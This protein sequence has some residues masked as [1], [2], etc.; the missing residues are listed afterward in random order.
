MKVCLTTLWG[1]PRKLT[2]RGLRVNDNVEAYITTKIALDLAIYLEK[3]GHLA[4]IQTYGSFKNKCVFVNDIRANVF[5]VLTMDKYGF[6]SISA[7]EK[8]EPSKY[9][10]SHFAYELSVVLPWKYTYNVLYPKQQRYGLLSFANKEFTSSAILGI[11]GIRNLNDILEY[12]N[13]HEVLG[14]AILKSYMDTPVLRTKTYDK[15]D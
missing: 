6:G 9:F 7:L 8:S 14:E 12:K 1:F 2:V 5:I 13:F 3:K 4:F 11:C 10:A 15:E